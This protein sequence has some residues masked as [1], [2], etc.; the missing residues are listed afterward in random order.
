MSDTFVSE[1]IARAVNDEAFRHL[2]LTNPGEA[3]SGYAV[4]GEQRVML[5]NLNENNLAE[6]AGALGDRATKGTWVPGT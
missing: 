1:I 3:L 5:G 6:F 4:T 2:L